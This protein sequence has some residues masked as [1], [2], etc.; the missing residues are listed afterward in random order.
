MIVGVAPTG[1][2]PG[3]GDNPAVPLT[4]EAIVADAITCAKAGATSIHVHVRD[5]DGR[6]THDADQYARI[7]A[8]IR[9]VVP[10]VVLCATTSSRVGSDLA[11][12]MTALDLPADVRPDLA[13]LTLGSGNFPRTVN[14]NPPDEMVALLERMGEQGV[15]P[16]LEVFELG[17]VNTL[18]ILR[19]RGLIPDPVIVHVLLGSMGTAPAF[20]GDLAHLVDRLPEGAEWGGAG[21]GIFQRPMV[22]ASAVL[23]GNVRTGLEDNPRG[24]GELPWTNAD[25][26]AFAVDAARLCGREIAT[27]TET[28]ARFGLGARP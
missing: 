24:H 2:V 5:A 20:V 3:P 26:V 11:A 21:I 10:E 6:P 28:R 22:V 14:A 19:E 17:M 25:A 27:A 9:Q 13:S 15:R 8:G 18:H 23:G 1:A 12:R 7:I 16:E 4:V